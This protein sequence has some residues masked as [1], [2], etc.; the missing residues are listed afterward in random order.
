MPLSRRSVGQSIR[1]ARSFGSSAR[2]SP[3]A[4]CGAGNWSNQ[5]LAHAGSS[6]RGRLELRGSRSISDFPAALGHD[7]GS[8]P[9]PP[10]MGPRPHPRLR[11]AGVDA[12]CSS[13]IPCFELRMG[14]RLARPQ[15]P[16]YPA[17]FKRS[18]ALAP[19]P[20]C[21]SKGIRWIR[22]RFS[23]PLDEPARAE[24]WRNLRG[25]PA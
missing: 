4:C 9:M 18:V 2:S 7:G 8:A 5:L 6:T 19:P 17:T 21:A 3:R 25:C 16:L 10:R 24:R 11:P 15:D 20:R 12:A 23:Y 22:A 13:V 1:R 14:A